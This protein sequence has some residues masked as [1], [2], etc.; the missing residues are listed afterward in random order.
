MRQLTHHRVK[1]DHHAAAAA[2]LKS[3]MPHKERYAEM[4]LHARWFPP[5]A[6]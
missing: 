2:I 3:D 5:E 4:I 1:Y 6:D